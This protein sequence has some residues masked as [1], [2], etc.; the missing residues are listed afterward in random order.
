MSGR[1]IVRWNMAYGPFVVMNADGSIGVDASPGE[2]LQ[3]WSRCCGAFSAFGVISL[4]GGGL[5]GL[6]GIG[7]PGAAPV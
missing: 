3:M 2:A 6:R 7:K 4:V 1:W 5:L